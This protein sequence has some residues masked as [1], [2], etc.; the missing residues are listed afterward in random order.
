MTTKTEPVSTL[1]L[2]LLF[3]AAIV[4]SP[5]IT[6]W[7][8]DRHEA[9]LSGNQPIP[10][11]IQPVENPWIVLD[12]HIKSCPQCGSKNPDESLCLEGFILFQDALAWEDN[13]DGLFDDTMELP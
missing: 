3:A 12:K 1:T 2:W 4:V 10:P 9:N 7:L 8:L 5:V 13:N 6:I 11:I